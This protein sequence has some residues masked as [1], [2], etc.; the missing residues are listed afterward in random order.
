MLNLKCKRELTPLESDLNALLAKYPAQETF[1]AV[2]VWL[3][4]NVKKTEGQ[5]LDVPTAIEDNLQEGITDI[6][7]KPCHSCQ[8]Y[9]RNQQCSQCTQ[10]YCV[11][12]VIKCQ[13]CAMV[14][15]HSDVKNCVRC[16]EYYCCR[17]SSECD[18]CY[19]TLCML[20]LK[21]ADLEKCNNPECDEGSYDPLWIS[22]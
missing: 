8:K 14:C 18:E 19:D 13:K 5:D 11:D 12:C 1:R 17:H 21:P 10:F 15:C 20:C 3:Q 2:S 16:D 4:E 6:H 7:Y 9:G 22:T